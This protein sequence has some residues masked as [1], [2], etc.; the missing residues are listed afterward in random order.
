MLKGLDPLLGPELL[1]THGTEIAPGSDVV[2]EDP[3]R[4][5]LSHGGLPREMVRCRPVATGPAIHS[6]RSVV[7]LAVGPAAS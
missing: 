6:P 5:W 3:E 4:H 2:G 1:N 7:V